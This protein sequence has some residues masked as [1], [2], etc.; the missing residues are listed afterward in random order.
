MMFNTYF[1][2]IYF[3]KFQKNVKVFSSKI[4]SYI[5]CCSKL[6]NTFLKSEY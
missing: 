6:K 2:I 1:I 4:D 5:L 3:D